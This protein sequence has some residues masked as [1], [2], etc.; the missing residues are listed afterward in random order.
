[1]T[2]KLTQGLKVFKDRWVIFLVG[3]TA[4][5][6]SEIAMALAPLLGADIISADSRQIYRGLDIG[7]AKPTLFQREVVN[8]HL[9]DV[10]DPPETFSVGQYKK[11]AEQAIDRC[12]RNNR[13]PLVV[14]GTG[15]YIRVLKGGLWE[16]P[17]PDWKLREK[18][19]QEEERGGEGTL[20]Q[21]LFCVDPDSARRIHP[22][23]C[24]KIIRALEVYT[25]SGKTLTQFQQNQRFGEHRYR[26]L[27]FGLHWNRK[28]LYRRIED[29]VEEMLKKGLVS[30]VQSLVDRNYHGGMS[31]MQAL[32]YRQV[33]PYLMGKMTFQE[34][35][36]GLKR[37]TKRFAKRQL[38]WF[39]REQNIRWIQLDEGS[40]SETIARQLNRTIQMHIQS[41]GLDVALAERSIAC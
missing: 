33:I 14:G 32:G 10:A 25:L 5:G 17:G 3:P 13:I 23:D 19:R 24:V 31:S 12:H 22:R 7:T 15:L 36:Q 28:E 2:P 38:T 26:S 9:I 6:K 39:R 16:G 11:L 34:M 4:S 21:K 29:R 18:F 30:E 20:H 41:G 35:T 37:D 8:H 1:M 40:D 27:L